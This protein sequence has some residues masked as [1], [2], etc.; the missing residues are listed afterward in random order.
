LNSLI[1][2]NIIVIVVKKEDKYNMKKLLILILVLSLIVS[3]VFFAIGCRQIETKETVKVESE[4]KSETSERIETAVLGGG[5]F[6]SMEAIFSQL[7]GV[8]DAEVG[9]AGGFK[10]NP[11]YEETN[12]TDTGHAEVVKV[13]F[14]PE[15]I[16]YDKLLEV[17]FYVHD[18]TTLN[19]QGND[20]GAQ[21]RSIILYANSEQEKSARE[22]IADLEEQKVYRDQ[23]VTEVEPLDKYYKAED[24]HQE[25]FEYNSDQPYCEFVVAP[26]VEKFE[27]KFA[28]YLK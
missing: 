17:Y 20:V 15:V 26:K 6:W 27:D 7:K 28:D 10:E 12:Q 24:Y 18:P 25:Y 22:Y 1:I 9:Y 8:V 21:Y 11:T 13:V 4:S 16:S 23:I 5:C 14:D 2:I 19:R 3:G